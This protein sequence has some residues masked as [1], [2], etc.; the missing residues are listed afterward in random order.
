M[1]QNHEPQDSEISLFEMFE[2][3]I[4]SWKLISGFMVIGIMVALSYLFL[5]KPQYEATALIEIAQVIENS[6]KMEIVSIEPPEMLVTRLRQPS[7]FN[8]NV[9]KTCGLENN[10]RAGEALVSLINARAIEK[11]KSI[12]IISVSRN[13]PDLARQCV[14][15]LFES[16][17]D[18]QA[19][20]MQLY[21][22]ETHNDMKRLQSDLSETQAF[23][24]KMDK[25][26]LY[27]TAYLTKR[28]ALLYYMKQIQ[29]LDWRLSSGR[30][31]RLVSPIYASD[32]ATFPKRK[33]TLTLGVVVGFILG[34]LVVIRRRILANNTSS[35]FANTTD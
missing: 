9:F 28:D 6:S 23:L 18:Q 17:R 34:L 33:L 22:E 5:V 24:T 16:I 27:Q 32:I 20:R 21:Q 25:A 14:N 19:E 12:V 4:G 3:I 2:S 31:T 8:P 30:P 7:A 26:G 13:T 15:G 1:N 10:E 11:L 35:F 29:E